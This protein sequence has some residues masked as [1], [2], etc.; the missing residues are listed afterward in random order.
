M[1]CE[2]KETAPKK[3]FGKLTSSEVVERLAELAQMEPKPVKCKH[4]KKIIPHNPNG[5]KPAPDFCKGTDCWKK[6]KNKRKHVIITKRSLEI[7]RE[8]R[9][10]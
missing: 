5:T 8:G 3:K 7:I 1:G 4:C 9:V 2:Q 6:G 10:I